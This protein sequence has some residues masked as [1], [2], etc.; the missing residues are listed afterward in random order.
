MSNNISL[1]IIL[2]ERVK[3]LRNERNITREMLAERIDVSTRFLA[4]VEAGKVGVSLSTLKN[5]CR[6][7]STSADYLIGISQPSDERLRMIEINSKIENIHPEFLPQLVKI[8][9]AFDE[10]VKNRE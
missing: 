10:A 7:L 1:N 3:A 4:D 9:D 8:I 2:G 5:L 6:A